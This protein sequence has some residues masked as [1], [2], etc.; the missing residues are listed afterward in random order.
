[1]LDAATGERHP[2]WSELDTPPGHHR[3]RAAPRC[4]AP[5]V[6]FT[7]G[8]RYIVALRNLRDAD[9]ATIP[10]TEA[11]AAYRDGTATDP[12][13]T[14][15]DNLFATLDGAG[16]AQDDLYA[17]WD[18]TV[19]SERNL[20]EKVL[21]IR[22]RRLR[23]AGDTDLAD[24]VV[25]GQ[26]PG[27]RITTVEDRANPGD[28]TLRH[29]EGT[30]SVPNYLSPQLE[31]GITG[32]SPTVANQVLDAIPDEVQRRPR[33][34]RSASCP[35]ASATSSA[36]PPR[37]PAAGSTTSGSTDGLPAVNPLQ[38]TVEVPFRCNIAR[39]QPRPPVEPDALRPRPPRQPGRGRRQQ[40]RRRC[41]SGA[42]PRAPS[43]GGA[44][45][46]PTCP[47]CA[48]ILLDVSNFAVDGRPG[49]AGL[50]ELPVPGPGPGAP[51]RPGRRPGVP[52]VPTA[53]R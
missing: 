33:R 18:F 39:S 35:S 31:V 26:A 37:S 3:R 5:A 27:Y 40:H 21:G 9:G 32:P 7:E 28:P 2:F 10:A 30:I 51:G 11:F 20:T 38:P 43:T 4:S 44:C 45:R 48:T 25:A 12:R 19:A 50:P 52:G 17:A 41:G 36:P 42:S 24:G 14:H 1:M 13:A 46:P 6:N 8:H 29:I 16:I 53:G 15:M 23:P 47:T 49:P 22:G 34:H